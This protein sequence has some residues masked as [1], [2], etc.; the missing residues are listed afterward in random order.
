MRALIQRVSEAS[1]TIDGECA[2]KIGPGIV[3]LL[4]ITGTDTG[5]EAEVLANKCA[6]LRIFNDEDGKMNLS[7][8]EV[9]GAALIISQFTLY[10]DCSRGRRPSCTAAARPEIAIPLYEKF[11]CEIR[12]FGIKTETGRFGAMM[13]VDIRNSGPVTLWVEVP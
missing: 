12:K 9:G 13:E 7:L 6:N 4:G 3:I 8:L 11:I 10:G 2:G 5:K 1:V